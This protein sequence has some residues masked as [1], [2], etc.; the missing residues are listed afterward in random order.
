METT[1]LRSH[2]PFSERVPVRVCSAPMPTPGTADPGLSVGPL[3]GPAAVGATSPT[4]F[5]LFR[6][7]HPS[8]TERC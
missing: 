8:A 5:S 7:Y 4:G 1:A 6:R 3:P 2:A